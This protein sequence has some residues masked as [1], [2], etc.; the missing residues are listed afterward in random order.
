MIQPGQLDHLL[1]V[2]A[3]V[4]RLEFLG[5]GRLE[6]DGEVVDPC[7]THGL[8]QFAVPGPVQPYLDHDAETRTDPLLVVPKHPAQAQGVAAI[9]AE[10]VVDDEEDL[11]A[12]F[13]VDRCENSQFIPQPRMPDTG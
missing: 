2:Q 9:L 10:Q 1:R 12:P 8:E 7:L 3:F 6:A 4:H 13:L 5:N 11:P